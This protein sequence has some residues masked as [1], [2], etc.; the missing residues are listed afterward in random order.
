MD[1]VSLSAV[2]L[3]GVTVIVA[4][5]AVASVPF[6]RLAVRFFLE[7]KRLTAL[8]VLGLMVASSMVTGSLAVGDSMRYGVVEGVYGNLGAVDE[9]VVSNGLFNE[10]VLDALASDG[11]LG[12]LTDAMAPLLV[13]KGAVQNGATRALESKASILG[14][15]SRFLAMGSFEGAGGGIPGGVPGRGE[16]VINERLAGEIGARTGD[17]IKITI[18]NPEFS[19]ESIFSPLAQQVTANVSV[20]AVV[21][22]AGL[23]RFTLESGGK[24]APNAFLSLSY[25]QEVVRAPSRLNTVAVSNRGGDRDGVGL[26]GDVTDRLQAVLD[27]AVGWGL[28]DGLGAGPI[29]EMAYASPARFREVLGWTKS[30]NFWRRRISTYALYEFVR[31]GELDKPPGPA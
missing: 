3:L 13:L 30:D 26:T 14:Y 19:I 9:A 10:S 4:L 20:I 8:A 29:A 12:G 5:A 7:R 16:A 31:R 15:D 11:A 28:C 21:R 24:V 25:L 23:G 2:A 6:F 17:V 1:L 18:R 27:E 22:D